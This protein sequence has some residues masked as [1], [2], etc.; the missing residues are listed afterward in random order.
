MLQEKKYIFLKFE[1]KCSYKLRF[2]HKPTF[3]NS[4]D[5]NFYS[6]GVGWYSLS[7]PFFISISMCRCMVA[8]SMPSPRCSYA[9]LMQSPVYFSRYSLLS[10]PDSPYIF[11]STGIMLTHSAPLCVGKTV[12]ANLKWLGCHIFP[13]REMRKFSKY[14]KRSVVFYVY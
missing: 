1:C 5:S 10:S 12:K 2:K 7:S 6:R 4:L 8:S 9:N 11:S 14:S 13:F 3:K